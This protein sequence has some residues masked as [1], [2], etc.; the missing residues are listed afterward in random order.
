M[1]ANL[2]DSIDKYK[3]LEKIFNNFFKIFISLSY[4]FLRKK[5]IEIDAFKWTKTQK[6]IKNYI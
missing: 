4:K 3:I 2:R 6:I 1:F 5:G